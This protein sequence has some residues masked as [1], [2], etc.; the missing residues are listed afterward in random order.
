[1][2]ESRYVKSTAALFFLS[3]K[4]PRLVIFEIK[5]EE[6]NAMWSLVRNRIK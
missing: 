4:N 1:M 5:M 2:N 6:V 3:A